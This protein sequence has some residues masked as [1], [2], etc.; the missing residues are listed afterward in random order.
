MQIANGLW[1]SYNRSNFPVYLVVRV[2]DPPRNISIASRHLDTELR[3]ECH[4]TVKVLKFFTVA[5][6]KFLFMAQNIPT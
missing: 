6:H 4:K 5:G 2:P 3:L 1:A